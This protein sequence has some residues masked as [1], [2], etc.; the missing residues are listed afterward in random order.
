MVNY[1]HDLCVH[2]NGVRIDNRLVYDL[3]E[4]EIKIV[5]EGKMKNLLI[6]RHAKSSW[7]NDALPDHDRPLNRRG[8]GDAPNVGKRL[9]AEG[10]TPDAIVCST[11][12]RAHQTAEAVAE[13]SGY[14]GELQVCEEL[15]D[16]GPEAYL[17]AIR[18]LPGE[19]DCAL[20]VGH[21]P[22]LEE[23]VEMLSGENVRLPTAALAYVQLDIQGW[24]DLNGEEQ[25]KLVDLWTPRE[26]PF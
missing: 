1:H 26:Q 9:R 12:R 19:V 21:N 17:E 14:A 7:K 4:D 15:Y 11:A 8:Q 5:E 16:G 24:K 6:L 23:L 2:R 25:G 22:D 10:L 18:N 3:A 13:Q 20:V